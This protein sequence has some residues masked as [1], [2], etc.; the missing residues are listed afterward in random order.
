MQ[1]LDIRQIEEAV[2]AAVDKCIPLTLA[3]DTDGW[4]NLHSRF[5]DMDGTHIF[6]EPGIDR[7]GVPQEF[8]PAEK[9]AMSFKL[10]HHK[11]LASAR[12]VGLRPYTLDDG[13]QIP[14]LSLCFP[15]HMQRVQR[16]AF[17][18]VE[19]PPGRVVRVSFWE[20][21]KDTEPVVALAEFPVW[22]GRVVD[23]SAGGFRAV[24]TDCKELTIEPGERVGVRIA[25]GAGE[26]SVYADAQFRHVDDA[27]D[28]DP[29]HTGLGFQFLG[30]PHTP[31]GRDVLR[32]IAQKVA[33]FG[34]AQANS[35]HRGF[36]RSR[37]RQ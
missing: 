29:T 23:I 28:E 18:R 32:L 16:R 10:K 24:F 22:S 14:V 20:G 5:I 13:T 31:E 3:V 6:V 12:V 15:T 26:D 9:V 27:G 30:L 36:H 34:R 17:S 7:A 1:E 11:Y 8:V 4:K 21:S 33:D 19:V 25:F 37:S 35:R 2:D